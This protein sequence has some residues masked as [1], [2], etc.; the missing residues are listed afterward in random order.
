[1]AMASTA[2][3][4]DDDPR[5]ANTREE[6]FQFMLYIRSLPHRNVIPVLQRN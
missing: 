3:P 6:P 2:R 4:A 1:M 5:V